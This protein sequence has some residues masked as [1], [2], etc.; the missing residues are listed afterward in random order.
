MAKYFVWKIFSFLRIWR[1][2]MKNCGLSYETPLL[3]SSSSPLFLKRRPFLRPP[4]HSSVSS[5]AP[6]YART[7]MP[8]RIAHSASSQ[9]LPSPFI[10]TRNSLI[11]CVLYMKEMPFFAFTREGNKGEVFTRK[12][13]FH[14]FFS[15]M[16]KRWRQKNEKQR[17][18]ARWGEEEGCRC[19]LEKGLLVVAGTLQV[20]D[21]PQYNPSVVLE[22]NWIIL[23]VCL[24]RTLRCK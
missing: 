6:P 21:E 14:S 19:T 2:W 8:L 3:F 13:L 10:F 18:R 7:D 12:S 17:T 23:F 4:C 1:D 16:M 15:R 20:S 22:S 24:F 5:S 9:F 11:Q